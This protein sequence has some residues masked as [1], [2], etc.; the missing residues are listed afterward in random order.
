MPPPSNMLL[1]TSPTLGQEMQQLCSLAQ[2]MS[3]QLDTGRGGS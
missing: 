1:W 3:A 2:T